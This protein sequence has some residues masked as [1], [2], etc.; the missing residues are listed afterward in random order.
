MRGASGWPA[1]SGSAWKS[2][3]ATRSAPPARRWNLRRAA[4][5]VADL[6]VRQHARQ[7]RRGI[8]KGFARAAAL[9]AGPAAPR[10]ARRPP[11][12]ACPPEVGPAHALSCGRCLLAQV[13]ARRSYPA[14]EP[15]C[16]CRL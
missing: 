11:V 7:V 2:A 9:A 14:R 4:A 10:R 12:A 16:I 15:V 5:R 13:F 6:T 3:S 1:S 8:A